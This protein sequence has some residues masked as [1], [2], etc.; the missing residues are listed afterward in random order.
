MPA[1]FITP[2]Q[3]PCEAAPRSRRPALE[4]TRISKTF[5]I[6]KGVLA[7]RQT[8]K[9]V[10]DV[11]LTLHAGE[12]LGLVGESGSGKSTLGRIASG[13]LLPD[14]GEESGVTLFGKPVTGP[15][16]Q[17]IQMIF[18]DSSSALNP[19]RSI[20]WSVREPLDVAG[21]IASLAERKAKVA[22]ML[23]LVGLSADQAARYPHEFSGGQRQR[24]VVAR[25]LI[26]NPEVIICDEPVSSLDASVQAQ[27]LN[28]LLDLKE[29]FQLSYLFISHDLGVVGHLSDRVAVMYL[30]RIVELAPVGELFQSPVHPYTQALLSSQPGSSFRLA[31][32]GNKVELSGDPPSPINL[33]SGCP[34]HPRCPFA[35]PVCREHLPPLQPV[36]GG[37]HLAACHLCA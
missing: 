30:G 31:R 19:R 17:P 29:Q 4:L 25:A 33:P 16:K 7:S 15:G 20:G 5:T 10:S 35:M 34:L 3:T 1:T 8:L 13:L 27:V 18:Q 24:I 11:S 6:K 36:S 23:D 37:D 12:I 32:T 26:Q 21:E 9:A 22:A 28:L 14:S 2:E